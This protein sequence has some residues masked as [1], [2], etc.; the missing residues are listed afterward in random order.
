MVANTGSLC[1]ARGKKAVGN[2]NELLDLLERPGGAGGE[3]QGYRDKKR[4][5]REKGGKREVYCTGRFHPM[6]KSQ[7]TAENKGGNRPGGPSGTAKRKRLMRVISK[8]EKKLR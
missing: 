4:K 3:G 1:W 7:N 2:K 8:K 6:T 5:K